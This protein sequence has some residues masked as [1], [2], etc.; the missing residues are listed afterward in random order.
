MPGS[1]SI[2]LKAALLGLLL[3]AGAPRL[4]AAPVEGHTRAV[5]AAGQVIIQGVT[6]FA[7]HMH[8]G[9]PAQLGHA[10]FQ[11]EN[12]GTQPL[13]LTVTDIE[14]LRGI[15]DCEHPPRQVASHPRFGGLFVE[16]SDPRESTREIELKPGRTIQLSV[17]FASVPAYG[18]Y[19]DRFAFRVHFQIGREKAA[20]I[21]EARVIRREP[22]RQPW[23]QDP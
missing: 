18:V 10:R 16:A 22:L 20:A 13:R 7:S 5:L 6:T 17:G 4:D 11:V 1:I 23:L 2:R 3:F 9:A 14:F 19:C 12:R 8:G 21:S 15:H